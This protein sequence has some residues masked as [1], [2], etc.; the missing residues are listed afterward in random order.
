MFALFY[1]VGKLNIIPALHCLSSGSAFSPWSKLTWF[2]S[3]QLQP[4]F[5]PLTRTRSFTS[6]FINFMQMKLHYQ[7]MLQHGDPIWSPSRFYPE[8]TLIRQHPGQKW[9]Q[10]APLHYMYFCFLLFLPSLYCLHFFLLYFLHA[11]FH[12]W[13]SQEFWLLYQSFFSHELT[14]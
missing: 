2:Q 14:F 11:L 1:C 6:S 8:P 12:L 5:I 4:G 10:A 3:F 9:W 7:G 13:T